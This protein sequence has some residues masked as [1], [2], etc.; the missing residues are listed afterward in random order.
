MLY[1]CTPYLAFVLTISKYIT[2]ENG[3]TP[4]VHANTRRVPK[5]TASIEDTQQAVNFITN[6]AAVHA[7]PLPGRNRTNKDERYLL[8]PSDMTKDFVFR[9]CILEWCLH[10]NILT[11]QKFNL[12]S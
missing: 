8:L 2:T 12:I 6:T 11:H 1:F 5:H 3:V 9:Q 7:L 10:V 4:R